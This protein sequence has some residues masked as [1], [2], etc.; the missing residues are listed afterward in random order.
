MQ[1]WFSDALPRRRRRVWLQLLALD[2]LVQS[3][4]LQFLSKAVAAPVLLDQETPDVL[5]ITSGVDSNLMLPEWFLVNPKFAMLIPGY[6][7]GGR[8]IKCKSSLKVP[9]VGSY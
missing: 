8:S 2:P 1:Q 3:V 6:H 5:Q 4:S 7:A 9:S